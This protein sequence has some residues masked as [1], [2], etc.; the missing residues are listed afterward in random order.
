MAEGA[1]K[2]KVET[3]AKKRVAL[4]KEIARL[5][6]R[7]ADAEADRVE[8]LLVE[9]VD[10]GGDAHVEVWR[11]AGEHGPDGG[12]GVQIGELMMFLRE[13]PEDFR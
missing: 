13:A 7:V 4:E 11:T 9:Q 6:S 2:T 5:Q 1:M 12:Y 10:R 8:A 3:T